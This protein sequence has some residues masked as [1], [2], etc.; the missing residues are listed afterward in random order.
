MQKIARA[1][2]TMPKQATKKIHNQ[3][4]PKT[5]FIGTVY[6]AFLRGKI[7]RMAKTGGLLSKG[8]QGKHNRAKARIP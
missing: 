8:G 7:G 2:W 4:I 1:K 3:I 6:H 5:A